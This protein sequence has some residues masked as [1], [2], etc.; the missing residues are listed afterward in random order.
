MFIFYFHK[1]KVTLRTC[2][3]IYYITLI[4]IFNINYL[5]ILFIVFETDYIVKIVVVKLITTFLSQISVMLEF[6]AVH[7]QFKENSFRQAM[8]RCGES[9]Q[10]LMRRVEDSHVPDLAQEDIPR[11]VAN[12][13]ALVDRMG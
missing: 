12:L 3:N 2:I 10:N 5:I 9:L 13:H 8:N 6:F 4:L 7:E 11:I 1:L